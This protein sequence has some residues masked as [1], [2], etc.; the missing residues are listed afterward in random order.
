[1]A[2]NLLRSLF[3]GVTNTARSG[4]TRALLNPR[5]II[6]PRNFLARSRGYERFGQSLRTPFKARA[7]NYL[8]KS[9][10]YPS[11]GVYLGYR[12][13][14]SA[15]RYGRNNINY[16]LNRYRVRNRIKTGVKKTG[17]FVRRGAKSIYRKISADP[18]SAAIGIYQSTRTPTLELKLAGA[19]L[20]SLRNPPAQENIFNTRA[21]SS[22][23]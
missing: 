10:G 3:R 5:N 7:N 8:A 17:S 9:I 11:R 18:A 21:F 15:G 20:G 19:N 14:R 4:G 2:G 1:M 22:W 6:S 13:L 16:F 23:S 12:G